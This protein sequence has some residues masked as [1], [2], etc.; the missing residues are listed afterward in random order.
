MFKAFFFLKKSSN[1]LKKNIT[2]SPKYV[3]LDKNG[4]TTKQQWVGAWTS[5]SFSEAQCCGPHKTLRSKALDCCQC[6]ATV[7][8]ERGSSEQAILTFLI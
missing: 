8:E 5:N 2:E 6:T 4:S 3:D 7:T 1:A